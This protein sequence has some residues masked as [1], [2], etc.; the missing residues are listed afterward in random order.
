MQGQSVLISGAGI[1]GPALAAWLHAAD[2]R[3][4]LVERSTSPRAGG[5]VIDF[6]GL[7]YDIAQRMG[8][9]PDINRLGYHLRAVRILD[10]HGKTV[11]GF[12]ARVMSE[13]TGG[14][15][16]TIARSDLARILLDRRGA[17][18]EV[19]FGDEIVGLQQDAGGVDV[20]FR[21]ASPRRFDL[22]IGADGLHSGVRRITFGADETFE[23]K[24]GYVAAAFEI[25][26]YR[27]REEETYVIY[28]QPGRM[29]GRFALHEDRTL[30]LFVLNAEQ[31]MNL[32][33]FDLSAQK[34]F[35]RARFAADAWEMPRILRHLSDSTDL[36][37][38]RVSQI[39]MERWSSGRVALLG[40]AAACI[41]LTGGQ[42]SALAI[43]AAYILAGEL[44]RSAP[45]YARAFGAYEARLRNFIAAKQRGAERFAAAFAPKTQTG[46]WF[47]NTVLRA[48]A[49]PG[50]ARLA[51]SR[52]ITDRLELPHYD[53]SR[54]ISPNQ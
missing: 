16:V 5:Y 54:P 48:T 29:V 23:K 6:W 41:S 35:L 26:G 11:S 38:D 50:V 9:L 19:I 45:D 43:I 15:F 40:D 18:T 42:G 47:R 20:N 36:Y 17:S 53:W 1:A 31:N 8:L 39:R 27:P 30:I 52:D 10:A 3:P 7:G 22:A 25:S 44:A 21:H 37:F 32:A 28:A 2:F 46:L 49:I 24:L 13:L 51:L 14:R 34:E 4:V 12:D 33:T